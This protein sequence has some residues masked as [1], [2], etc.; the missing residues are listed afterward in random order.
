MDENPAL[1]HRSGFYNYLCSD[2]RT[3][4]VTNM[5]GDYRC[6]GCGEI[7][8]IEP[9]Q[10]ISSRVVKK[11]VAVLGVAAF[12]VWP[13]WGSEGHTRNRRSKAPS[14]SLAGLAADNLD[15]G[16]SMPAILRMGFSS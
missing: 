15:S 10:E 2:C 6:Q 16:K 5:P 4:V 7:L 12:S 11:R 9:L 13:Q 14:G 8:V 3:Q 1:P